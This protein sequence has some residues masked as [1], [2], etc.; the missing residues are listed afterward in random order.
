MARP[1][2]SK[3][4]ERY[5]LGPRLGAG[6]TARV[7]AAWSV[8]LQQEVA[9]KL[10][11]DAAPEDVPNA[12]AREAW[13]L[14]RIDHPR[15]VRCFGLASV[16]G[17]PALVM[18]RV[19]GVPLGQWL[20]RRPAPDRIVAVLRQTAEA[21]AATHRAGILHGDV[22]A[23]NVMVDDTDSAKL[24]DFGIARPLEGVPRRSLVPVP[25]L[26]ASL[27]RTSSLSGTPAYMAP[28]IFAGEPVDAR[29]D[30]FSFCVLAYEAL[31][32]KRPFAGRSL[33]D[34]ARAVMWDR[35]KPIPEEAPISSRVRFVL[36]RGLARDPEDRFADMET[37]LA[38]LGTRLRGSGRHRSCLR[39][40]GPRRSD[41][42]RRASRRCAP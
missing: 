8:E 41:T 3:P 4:L 2:T 37:L 13:A 6:G 25:D 11:P 15:V 23:S 33:P 34:L 12:L 32:G 9:L 27:T 39:F 26:F 28:E 36:R 30:Q 1:D 17:V 42:A 7:H 38:S 24:I 16:E 18:E 10:V 29:A 40:V 5:H 19:D 14:D 20:A 22:K 35:P 21:L 31:L